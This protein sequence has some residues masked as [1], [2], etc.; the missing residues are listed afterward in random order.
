MDIWRVWPVFVLTAL[1]CGGGGG[2]STARLHVD[3]S[4]QPCAAGQT[5]M[6]YYGI[7]GD[8]GPLLRTC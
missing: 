8:K 4:N 5:C 7:A 2:A 3:C 6:A 1:G